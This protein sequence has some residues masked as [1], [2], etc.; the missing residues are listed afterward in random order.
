MNKKAAVISCLLFALFCMAARAGELGPYG[1]NLALE[2]GLDERRFLAEGWQVQSSAAVKSGGEEISRPGYAAAGWHPAS[3]PA[4]VLAVLVENGVYPDPYFG[5]NFNKIPGSWPFPLDVSAMPMPLWSPFR[6]PWWFRTEFELP[7]QFHGKRLHLHFKGIN[8]RANIFVNGKLLADNQQVA[9]AYRIYEFEATDY[10]KPGRN[11]L[12][13]EVSPPGHRDLAFTWVDWAPGPPDKNMGVWREVFITTSG[14]GRLRFPH[15]ITELEPS[16]ETARLTVTAELTNLSGRS[17]SGTLTGKIEDR[18]FAKTVELGPREQKLVSF[19]PD[20]FPELV[21]ADPR[22]WWPAEL[23][24]QELYQLSLEFE[25]EGALSDRQDARFGIR[26][27]VSEFAD[28]GHLVFKLN[29][30]KILIRGAGWAPD[31]LFRF[32]PERMAAEIR[33]VREMNLN[34]IRLEAKLESD[35][36]FDQ[37]DEQGVMIMAGWCCCHHWERWS[38]WD[39]EDHEVARLSLRDQL[40][41]MRNHPSVFVWLN[42]SDFPPPARVE[43]MYLDTLAELDWQNPILSSATGKPAEFSGPSGVKMTGPYEWVPPNYWLED[44]KQGGAWGFNT[45]TSPGPAVPPLETLK[46][47]LPEDKLWPINRY[48][49]FHCGRGMFANLKVY[50]KAINQRYG[51]APTL[52]DYLRKAEA[53]NYEGQ[54]AMMEAFGRNK[55]TAT[56]VIQWMLNNAWPALIWHL[57]DYHLLPGAGYFGTKKA[58]QPLHIMFSYDDRSVA[59]VNSH[60]RQ[61]SGLTAA[62]RMHDLAGKEIHAEQKTITVPANAS[63]RAFTLPE[64]EGIAGAYFV[65]LELRDQ[66]GELVS[67]N[68][69]WLSKKMDRLNWRA[70]QWY[71]TPVKSY[72]DFTELQHLPEVEL[73]ISAQE[74]GGEAEEERIVRVVNASDRVAF[75][76]RLKL[77]R[78][79]SEDLVLPVFWSDNYFSLLP[80]EQRE[81]SVNYRP[82]EVGGAGARVCVE[83]WNIK[84]ACLE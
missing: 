67:D 45:E 47:I 57:Y 58:N 12:A 36:L 74:R 76:V 61:F 14:P 5:M 7:E 59:L 31:L 84:P 78:G 9:G 73:A 1:A 50:N 41:R 49:H 68:F 19:T 51:P 39:A 22:R 54:R 64:P 53:M 2:E 3:I 71:Y 72:A 15:V 38:R 26:E 33:Y 23:G 65:K 37:C 70:T 21:I 29:G 43:K 79:R 81:V 11:A 25:V 52:E 55:F 17:I 4:T 35:H 34:A 77:M 46:K 40:R 16:G 60:R 69:Y 13:L 10:L 83:G 20:Q 48:W 63:L 82:E 62:A 24:G 42:G 44:K 30:E 32:N 56:G 18:A 75:M 66:A 8:F 80:G 28:E 27:V 6:K